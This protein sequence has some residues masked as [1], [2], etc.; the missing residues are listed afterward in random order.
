MNPR[1][2]F[3]K[4]DNIVLNDK[5]LSRS[6]C[7]VFVVLAK[8]SRL[9]NNAR[10]CCLKI[11]TIAT[12]AKYCKRA[13]QSAINL[14]VELG[15]VIRVYQKTPSGDNKPSIFIIIGA[16]AQRYSPT[17]NTS[18]TYAIQQKIQ[19]AF[20]SLD[21]TPYYPT[22]EEIQEVYESSDYN[23]P[24]LTPSATIAPPH[25][26][27][28]PNNKTSIN[29]TSASRKSAHES[30]ESHDSSTTLNFEVPTDSDFAVSDNKSHSVVEVND[31]NAGGLSEIKPEHHMNNAT[32][33]VNQGEHKDAYFNSCSRY[34]FPVDQAP[35]A[36]RPAA[37]LLLYK[38]GRNPF[39]LSEDE[40]HSL[41]ALNARHT[42]GRVITEIER[43]VKRF[44]DKGTPLNSLTFCYIEAAMKHQKPTIKPKKTKDS[45]QQPQ[46]L[47][48][49][50]ISVDDNSEAD[51]IN[52][53]VAELKAAEEAL[54]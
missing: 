32:H 11:S 17:Q 19:D 1:Y 20:D 22:Q 48:M 37:E 31:E 54:L 42:P 5:D 25:A 41:F 40:L 39:A 24:D 9:C 51:D 16:D 43:A 35:H 47:Q 34:A 30:H 3:T 7:A 52:E 29:Y 50:E 38:T 26:T 4:L 2:S 46:E 27:I 8:H 6:A 23:I 49:P 28:A 33:N 36:F 53:L 14:L 44:I 12:E 21:P 18:T 15:L 45:R 10:S 13:V